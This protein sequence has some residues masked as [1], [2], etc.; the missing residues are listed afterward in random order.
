[1]EIEDIYNINETDFWMRQITAN[2]IIYNSVMN[3]LIALKSDN[4]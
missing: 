4:I 2:Y 1:M 3:H